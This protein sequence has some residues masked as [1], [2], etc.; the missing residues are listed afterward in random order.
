[1]MIWLLGR[2]IQAPDWVCRLAYVS[3]KAKTFSIRTAANTETELKDAL[4]CKFGF[5]FW[6]KLKSTVNTRAQDCWS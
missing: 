2:L 5:C 1:M 3:Q 6:I 4:W